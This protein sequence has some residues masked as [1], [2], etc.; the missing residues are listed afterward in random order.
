MS[1][2]PFPSGGRMPSSEARE[3]DSSSGAAPRA[4]PAEGPVTPRGP[5]RGAA[6][7]LIVSAVSL[8]FVAAAFLLGVLIAVFVMVVLGGY[9]LASVVWSLRHVFI[10]LAFAVVIASVV[11]LL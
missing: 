7:R 1:V 9:V 4:I 5:L 10:G 8:A 2:H 6:T 3:G 11:G